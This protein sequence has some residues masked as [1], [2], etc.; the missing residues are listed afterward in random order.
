MNDRSNPEMRAGNARP[1][2]VL[3]YAAWL[4]FSGVSVDFFN[5]VVRRLIWPK[6]DL[7]IRLWLAEIFFVSG[8]LK[9]TAWHTALDLATNEYAVSWMNPVSAAYTGV[10]IEVLGGVLLAIGFMTRY[11]AIPMLILSLVIQFAY[12]PFDNQLFWAL[13]FAWYAI[14]GAGP[15]S[16]DSLLR[17]GLADSALPL[18]PSIVRA[19]DRVRVH[20]GPIILSAMRLWLAS[21]LLLAVWPGFL[22]QN[23]L[24]AAGMW[25]PL[26]TVAYMPVSVALVGGVLLL[27]GFATRYVSI[28]LILALFVGTMIDPRLN[29][30]AYLLMFFVIFI[31]H[32][33]GAISVDHIVARL[34]EKFLPH[35]HLSAESLAALPRVVIVGAGFGGISCA[36]GLRGNAASVTVIDQA[37]YHLFQPLLYQV[38]TAALSPGDIAA[39]V[40]PLFRDS[41]S[42]RVLLGKVSS[43]D[44]EKQVVS[45][46]EKEI[47]YDYLV[48]AT[49]AAHSYFG[50]DQW[51]PYAPGLKRIEDATDIRRRILTAFERAEAAEDSVA[52][53]SLLTFLIVGGGPT[54]VE[55][56]GAIAELARFGME[57]EFRNFDPAHARVILVQSAP[58][59]LP[60]FPEKLAAIAQRSLEQ[61]GVDVRIGSRVEH[62]DAD[63]VTVSGERI[64]AKTVLWAAGVTASP[65]AKWL[66][67]EADNAGRVIVGPDLSVP[68]LPNVYAIGDTAASNAW[69]GQGVPGLAPA[70]K[71]GG[72]YVARHIRAR[73]AGKTT[74][75]P[76]AYRHLGSLATIGR[77][78]AVADFG[79]L[80]LWGAPAWWLWGF[81]HVGFLVGLRNR[82]STMVNWFWTYLTF[83]GGIRLITGSD[84]LPVAEKAVKP[85]A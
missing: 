50:K 33:A 65:A 59:L 37:N 58:R 80:R 73:I 56:A 30:A 13:L 46:G 19:S 82:L 38:A 14:Q 22:D 31:V 55:L 34:F 53:E 9:L 74:P 16:I 43:I 36:A 17:R 64:P 77:K 45:T 67:V 79:F 18:V 24:A 5:R 52:R 3:K 15:L 40:R 51:A 83:G 71:Q 11:A 78:A 60:A 57:K 26:Q 85:S 49:G 42:T 39:P 44:T 21:T 81:V 12:L 8:V 76:F 27:M 1:K 35:L 62:I 23:Q 41:F 61:L 28:A 54:G 84:T 69:N 47:P 2:T 68:G 25:L 29:D 10:G 48:L 4:K 72:A 75:P 66:Q 32:G 63:G 7:V 6:A 20:L 70:A